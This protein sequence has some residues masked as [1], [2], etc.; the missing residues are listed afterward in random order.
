MVSS[1]TNIPR[2][3][4]KEHLSSGWI[5]ET[6]INQSRPQKQSAGHRLYKRPPPPPRHHLE[7][8]SA[9]LCL[10]PRQ[11]T[12]ELYLKCS[13]WAKEGRPVPHLEGGLQGRDQ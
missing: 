3:P 7:S 5:Q 11:Q 9:A 8:P 1:G 10:Q 6:Q 12:A 4:R 2:W 13:P